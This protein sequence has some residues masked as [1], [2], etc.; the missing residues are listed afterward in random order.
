MNELLEMK[1]KIFCE[2]LKSIRKDGYHISQRELAKRLGVTQ[3][4]LSK[5]ERGYRGI[6]IVEL[7]EICHAMTISLAEFA[8]RL[9]WKLCEKFPEIKPH[10]KH[11]LSVLRS[12]SLT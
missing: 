8:A 7:M 9:E 2:T 4:Y 5:I 1:R 11:I 12:F 6:D 10:M 3:S